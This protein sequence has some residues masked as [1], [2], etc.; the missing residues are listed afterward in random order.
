MSN[1]KTCACPHHKMLPILVIL[2]AILF[3]LGALQIVGDSLVA[4]VW[5]ILVGIAGFTKLGEG[6]CKCC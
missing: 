2:F 3:L 6:K 4:I 5:P 1:M